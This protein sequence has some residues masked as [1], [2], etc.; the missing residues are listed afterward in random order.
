MTKS[1]CEHGAGGRRGHG[2]L[3]TLSRPTSASGAPL[4]YCQQF[5]PVQGLIYD[6][7]YRDLKRARHDDASAR[8]LA[9]W[10][11]LLHLMHFPRP[12][13]LPAPVGRD[14]FGQALRCFITADDV[15]S[16]VSALSTLG[17][18]VVQLNIVPTAE[19]ERRLVESLEPL[20]ENDRDSRSWR[21]GTETQLPVGGMLYRHSA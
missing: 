19:A 21:H 5:V 11:P 18:E 15:R 10:V 7:R 20:N 1:R 2:R 13:D 6:V 9:S 8:G 14:D 12:E 17:F 3:R 16:G 4:P